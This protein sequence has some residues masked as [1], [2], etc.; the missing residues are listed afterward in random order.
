MRPICSLNS[1]PWRRTL[2]YI[3]WTNALTFILRGLWLFEGLHVLQGFLGSQLCLCPLNLCLTS[4][5][6]KTKVFCSQTN[7]MFLIFDKTAACQTW[8][9][10]SLIHYSRDLKSTHWCVLMVLR[11]ISQ[12]NNPEL[13]NISV[14]E[15]EWGTIFFLPLRPYP[16]TR[17]VHFNSNSISEDF[18][19]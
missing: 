12:M 15:W 1:V 8:F 14:R 17:K 19:L 16:V 6:A 7:Y 10:S 5:F 3:T 2:F 11:K 9:L 13:A 4:Q 18:F